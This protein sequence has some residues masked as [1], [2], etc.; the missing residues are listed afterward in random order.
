MTHISGP[1]RLRPRPVTLRHARGQILIMFAAFL[2][3]IVG[4]TGLAI[5]LGYAF[6]ARRAMQNAADAGA[7]A[8][9]QIVSK[10]TPD[11][12]LSALTAV[13]NAVTANKL[14][15]IVPTITACNYVSDSETILG[16]CANPVPANTTGVRVAVQETHGTFFIGAVPGGPKTAAAGAVATAHVQTLANPPS[17]GP[18]IV[19]ASGTELASGNGTM[20]ILVQT[21]G[22]WTVNPDAV[23]VSFQIHG[24]KVSTCGITNSN[25]KGYADTYANTVNGNLTIPNYFSYSTGTSAGQVT[26]DVQGINGCQAGGPL[27]DCVAIL[28]IA[29]IDP[30]HPVTNK[31]VWTVAFAPFYVTA[32]GANAHNGVLMADYVVIGGGRL[33]WQPDYSGPTIIRLTR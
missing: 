16:T 4:V 6:G 30:N 20:D 12:P 21:N 31:Q 18:F 1:V 11:A 23:G 33:G 2:V 7:L 24:P 9:A 25:F 28:P 26:T 5:D 22:V 29:A 15:T 17:D 27:N 14:G 10:S 32:D 8:G 19:C 3:V 13:Q